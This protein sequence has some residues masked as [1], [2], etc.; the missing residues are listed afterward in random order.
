MLCFC[1]LVVYNKLSAQNLEKAFFFVFYKENY[2]KDKHELGTAY[3]CL[4]INILHP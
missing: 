2:F 1:L 3:I 4:Y